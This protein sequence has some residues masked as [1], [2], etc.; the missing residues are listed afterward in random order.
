[1]T[2]GFICGTVLAIMLF[3]SSCSRNSN[4]DGGTLFISSLSAGEAHA[5]V[6]LSDGRVKCWGANNFG[7]LGN[8]SSQTCL[9]VTI[10]FLCSTQPVTV[11]GISAA[12]AVAAGNVNTCAVLSSGSVKCW[13]ANASGSL[14]DGTTTNSSMPV[15]V[16]GISTAK[17]VSAG[18]GHSCALLLDGTLKCWGLNWYGQL[19]NGVNIVVP[20]DAFNSPVPVEV[21]GIANATGVA[22]G[23][24]HTCAALSDGTAKCWGNN[25]SGQLGSGASNFSSTPI[26]VTGISIAKNV[27]VGLAHSCALLSN[28]MIQ[29]WGN[30][31]YGQLGN[32][33]AT[34]SSTPV[35][36]QGISNAVAVSAGDYHTC[37]MLSDGRV[38]CWGLNIRGQLGTGTFDNSLIPVT[39]AGIA[40]A[41]AIA[42]GGDGMGESYSCALLSDKTVNCW[43]DN[44]F[45]ELGDGTTN[46]SSTPVEVVRLLD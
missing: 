8:A 39:V 10:T 34:D 22:A 3:V 12:I 24:I 42:A 11:R 1:M 26:E 16:E 6:V 43:G 31:Q 19:G 35:T 2:N 9:F 18:G 23:N 14:G 13:G 38:Q 40:T 29:C 28:G 44:S 17:A 36:V 4:G 46:Y 27:A 32:G 21:I 15:T 45:G 5:C 33:T 37:A 7:Q 20:S 25:A 30:N 41:T